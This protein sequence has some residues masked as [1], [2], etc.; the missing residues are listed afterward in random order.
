MKIVICNFIMC[1]MI[2]YVQCTTVSERPLAYEEKKAESP[3][4]DLVD[5]SI[6]LGWIDGDTFRAKST[7][8]TKDGAISAAQNAVI[9]R[10]ITD[11][12]KASDK[13][14]D[15]KS[16]GVAVVDEFGSV[17]KEGCVIR[18]KQEDGLYTIIYEVKSK[19]LKNRVLRKK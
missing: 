10:F 16:T 1:T 13:F 5:F 19:N 6:P 11:R 12:V 4:T 7:S 17:V 18:E 3:K 15:V 14:V 8:K 9:E 2:L